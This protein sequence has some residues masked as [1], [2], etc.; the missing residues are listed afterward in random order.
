MLVLLTAGTL[1]YK[2]LEVDLY[3]F[4]LRMKHFLKEVDN[5]L[6]DAVAKGDAHCQQ[7]LKQQRSDLCQG[8]EELNNPGASFASKADIY[9]L[10]VVILQVIQST[11]T[12]CYR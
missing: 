10:G 5:K 6:Q 8:Q 2:P 11:G 9:S 1:M 3:E 4:L 7:L 12:I